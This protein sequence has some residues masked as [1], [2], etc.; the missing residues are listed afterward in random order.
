MDVFVVIAIFAVALLLAELLLP[1]GGVLAGLGALGLIGA[2]VYLLQLDSG[3]G[4][5]TRRMVWV[6]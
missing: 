2:G 1:T 5:R 6:P 4:Q 3:E